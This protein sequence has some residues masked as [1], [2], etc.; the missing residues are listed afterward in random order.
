MR[1]AL[2]NTA[3]DFDMLLRLALAKAN[4]KL[5]D[6]KRLTMDPS[7]V[8]TASTGGAPLEAALARSGAALGLRAGSEQNKRAGTVP[9]SHPFRRQN[10]SSIDP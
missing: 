6:I 10:S 7:T 4:M 5:D 2:Q 8:V 3:D 1:A 9:G